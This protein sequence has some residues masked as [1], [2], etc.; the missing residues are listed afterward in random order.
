MFSIN[1][2]N[3][4]LLVVFL[5]LKYENDNDAISDFHLVAGGVVCAVATDKRTRDIAD[6]I[7]QNAYEERERKRKREKKIE[8]RTCRRKGKKVV[9]MVCRTTGEMCC[10]LREMAWSC[11]R[12][13]VRERKRK[14]RENSA[15]GKNNNNNQHHHQPRES[16]EGAK[17]YTGRN[18]SQV[19]TCLRIRKE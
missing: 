19:T 1:N 7:K 17:K 4:H 12:K 9:A 10:R 2:N 14:C 8:F 3:R 13:R 6:N 18:C 11:A 15:N 5:F 16:R